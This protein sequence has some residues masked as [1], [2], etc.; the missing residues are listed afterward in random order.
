MSPERFRR[1]PSVDQALRDP[2]LAGLPRGLALRAAR[3]VLT[4]LRR[5]LVEDPDLIVPDAMAQIV[6]EAR[7]QATPHLRRV[8][9]ATGIVP[10]ATPT[11]S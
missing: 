3:A 10:G 5:A 7:R 6:A 8:I 2:A 1:L 11:P 4:K 9:N